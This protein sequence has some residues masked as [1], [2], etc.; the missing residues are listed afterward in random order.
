M[1]KFQIEKEGSQIG[2]LSYDFLIFYLVDLSLNSF[3]SVDFKYERSR[4]WD[5]FGV[6]KIRVKDPD[7]FPEGEGVCTPTK[8]YTLHLQPKV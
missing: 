3:L 4:H 6:R 1:F 2:L 7:F 5:S 8:L